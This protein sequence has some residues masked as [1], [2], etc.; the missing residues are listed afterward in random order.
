VIGKK[1]GEVFKGCP[2]E[3]FN[4]VNAFTGSIGK[5]SFDKFG[6]NVKNE[7]DL[8]ELKDLFYPKKKPNFINPTLGSLHC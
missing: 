5:F 6:M 1:V 8:K 3:D 7:Q 4:Y 2:K